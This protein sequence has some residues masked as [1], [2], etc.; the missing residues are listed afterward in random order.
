MLNRLGSRP[1]G[2][3]PQDHDRRLQE[4]VND[5]T[6]VTALLWPGGWGRGEVGWER[7]GQAGTW[8]WG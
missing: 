2:P 4:L 3:G 5:P 7:G 1:P 8:T 6:R